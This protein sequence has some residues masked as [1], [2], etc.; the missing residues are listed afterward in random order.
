[1]NVLLSVASFSASNVSRFLDIFNPIV[2]QHAIVFKIR[3]RPNVAL[4]YLF[5]SRY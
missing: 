2:P 4:I 5:I 3:F 1:M